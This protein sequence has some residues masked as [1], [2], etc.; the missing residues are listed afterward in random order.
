M[1]KGITLKGDNLTPMG[2]E[3]RTGAAIIEAK[4]GPLTLTIEGAGSLSNAAEPQSEEDQGPPI[5]Q[6]PPR[7]YDR[8]YVILGLCFSILGVAFFILYRK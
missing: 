7:I 4:N 2:E 5:D 8:L 3:P 6:I 1:P